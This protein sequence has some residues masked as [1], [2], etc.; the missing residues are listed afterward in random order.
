MIG[1][2]LLEDPFSPSEEDVREDYPTEDDMMELALRARDAVRDT[3]AQ[4]SGIQSV[5][6]F[7]DMVERLEEWVGRMDDE[8]IEDAREKLWCATGR[9]GYLAHRTGVIPQIIAALGWQIEL[10]NEARKLAARRT[11]EDRRTNR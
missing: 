2:Y 4:E 10:S 5:T 7:V 1:D 8:I 9:R 3:V 6:V 11:K